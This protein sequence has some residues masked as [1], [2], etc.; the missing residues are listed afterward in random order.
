LINGSEILEKAN[1]PNLE[2]ANLGLQIEG[3]GASGNE[4]F[5]MDV[6]DENLSFSS[7]EG[8]TPENLELAKMYSL[9]IKEFD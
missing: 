1:N 4:E 3:S 6:S 5:N 8:R 7:T 2:P 9:E